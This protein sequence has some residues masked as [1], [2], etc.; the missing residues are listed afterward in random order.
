MDE[1]I[2]E[3]RTPVRDPDGHLYRARALGRARKD[4]TW[5]GWL[6]FAP[7]G[8]GGMARHTPRETT[9]PGPAALLYWALGIEPVYLE[10]AVARA[11]PRARVSS[12]CGRAHRACPPSA[13][14][15]CGRP[16]SSRS[17]RG[18]RGRSNRARARSA[19][20]ARADRSVP[21]V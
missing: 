2:H 3:F 17:R 21:A 10:G 12:R 9:Q 7:V 15:P 6:E 5:I 13:S 18:S 19:R 20:D 4:G 8:F 16:S 14:R 11:G 1:L